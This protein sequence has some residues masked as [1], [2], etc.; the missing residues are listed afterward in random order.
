MAHIL[1]GGVLMQGA[2]VEHERVERQLASA[3]L[4]LTASEVHGALCGLICAGTT[5]AQAIWFAELFDKC[6]DQDL[7]VV[8][9]QQVLS[10]LH[11]ETRDAIDDPGLGFQPLLPDDDS[12]IQLRAKAVCDW[13]QGFLYG[14]G[15]AGVSAEQALS[16]HTR[17]ALQDF[18]AITRMDTEGL[19]GDDEESEDDLMQVMEFLWV[20]AMLVHDDLVN[21]ETARS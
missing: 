8:E 7:L 10:R 16:D 13:S 15:L 2:S 14:I 12:P 3:D 19:T 20:A 17:E 4:E 9:C 11:A 21:D 5:D 1:N 6:D 18:S